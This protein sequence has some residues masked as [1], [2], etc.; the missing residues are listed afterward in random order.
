[1]FL[2]KIGYRLRKIGCSL[3]AI[4]YREMKSSTPG[5]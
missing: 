3:Q 5:A 1:V 2:K 4:G